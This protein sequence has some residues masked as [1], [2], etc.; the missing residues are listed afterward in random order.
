MSL[1]EQPAELIALLVTLSLLPLL[2]V[3]GTSFL[4]LSVVFALLRNALGIQQI[5]RIL[6]FTGWR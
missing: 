6:R 5:P 1:T 4:K 3:M 2:I